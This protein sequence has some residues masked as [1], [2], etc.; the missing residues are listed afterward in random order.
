MTS[1]RRIAR[2]AARRFG[3]DLV[4]YPQADPLWAITQMIRHHRIDLVLDVG[5]NDGGF[6]VGIRRCGYSGPLISFEPLAQPYERLRAR[7]KRDSSWNAIQCAIGDEARKVQVHVAGN[8]AASSSVLPMLKRHRDAAPD[9]RYVGVEEVDQ[10]RLDDLVHS[11]TDICGNRV[12]LK[13]DVQGYEHAVMDGAKQL[14]GSGQVCG[15]QLE[16]SF[17]SLY[18]GGMNWQEGFDRAASLG[19]TLM[20][21]VPG[22]TDAR[23]GQMLQADAVFYRPARELL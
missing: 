10:Y 16:L 22:F 23:S 17:A 4:R 9:S 2:L 6:A 8:M 21:L 14:L 19:M 20:S 13:I 5:A 3:I 15:L 11:F 18:E 7:S 12:Y 1:L